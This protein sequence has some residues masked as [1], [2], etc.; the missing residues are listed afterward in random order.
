MRDKQICLNCRMPTWT[1]LDERG[2]CK[3][4]APELEVSMYWVVYNPKTR[5]FMKILSEYPQ[6]ITTRVEWVA[7]E[8]DASHFAT[9]AEIHRQLDFYYTC[10]PRHFGV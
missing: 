2:L 1:G 7:S 3:T 6:T 8:K 4:C 9:Y 5:K 10:E